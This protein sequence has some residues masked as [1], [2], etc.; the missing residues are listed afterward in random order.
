NPIAWFT[1]RKLR[2]YPPH[3]GSGCFV[4]SVVV[5]RLVDIGL[6][7]LRRMRYTG[8]AVVNFKQ[9]ARSGD[10]VVH[11]I[12]PRVSQW[13]LLATRCGVDLPYSAYADAAGE[14]CPPSSRQRE[15][16]RYVNLRADLKAM[17]TYRQSGE[18][19]WGEWARS[20]AAPLVH[21]VFALDDLGV[22]A[23]SIR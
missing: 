21:Q 15:G 2:I 16:I 11:E 19:R 9:D 3:A 12:N 18:W 20:F 4:V 22:L 8:I 14:R 5:P 17:A 13:N 10:F 6:E 23:A 1:G 7:V